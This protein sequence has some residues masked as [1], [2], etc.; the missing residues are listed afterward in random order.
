MLVKEIMYDLADVNIIPAITSEI[1]HRG[2]INSFYKI[3][4]KAYYPIFVSPMECVI[5]KENFNIYDKNQVIP[6]LPRTESLEDRLEY[7]RTNRW[8][9]FG[10]SEFVE[11]FCNPDKLIVSNPDDK[12]IRIRVLIDNANGHMA[13][14]PE[15]IIAAKKLAKE[16]NYTIEIMAGNIAHP[17]TYTVL[18]KAGAD[19][20]RCAVGTGNCCTTASNT[21]TYMGM[22]TLIDG[23]YINKL[24]HHLDCKIIADGGISTY[25]R[26]IKALA[27]GADY[28]MIGS[29]FG[30]CFESASE[31]ISFDKPV[32]AYTY[33]T[34][35]DINDMRWSDDV[36]EAEKKD[37]IKMYAPMEKA[38]WGMSTRRAQTSIALAQG[39][40]K[41]EIKT[42]TSEGV[43]KK[44]AVN[45][46]LHQ[47]IENFGDYLRSSMSYTN[48]K[49]LTDYIGGP[50]LKICSESA[51]NAKNK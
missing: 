39:Q 31:F 30:S 19:Y 2:D 27:L 46:T 37:I 43:E 17:D 3:D 10:L 49:E 20:V 6:I 35:H 45:Y 22:A 36:A 32:K 51:K 1:R 8:S 15:A 4:G 24:T 12:D 48:F 5:N 7:A 38:V 33:Y 40:K 18:A 9:S 47:W 11:Y 14:L 29:T 28:V 44:V 21:A 23:C 50:I 25:D 26:A 34:L 16:F 13:E 41:N 42:K